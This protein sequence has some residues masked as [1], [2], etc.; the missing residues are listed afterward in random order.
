MLDNVLCQC[1]HDSQSNPK[2]TIFLG[3]PARSDSPCLE[4]VSKISNVGSAG[5]ITQ[6]A[7]LAMCASTTTH[8]QGRLMDLHGVVASSA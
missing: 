8:L 4:L 7:T 3:L 1:R 5:V 6:V 2:P